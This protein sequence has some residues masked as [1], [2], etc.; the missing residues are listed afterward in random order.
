[1]PGHFCS[2]QEMLA[3]GFTLL[4][5]GTDLGLLGQAAAKQLAFLKLLREES[6]EESAQ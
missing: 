6:S 5:T 2:A 3:Q 1:M 4:A